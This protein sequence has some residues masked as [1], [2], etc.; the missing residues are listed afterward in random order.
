[1]RPRPE[2][3]A[4]PRSVTR[5][6][7]LSSAGRFA[8]LLSRRRYAVSALDQVALSLF[9]FVLNIALLAMLTPVQFGVV[10]LWIAVSQ[11]TI[12][13]QNAVIG[14]ALNTY[15]PAERDAAARRRLE[16]A[17]D[18]INLLMAIAAA[19]AI[20]AVDA[21]AE[22]D[23][24][25]R[26]TA[27][28]VAIPLFVVANLY[29]EYYR[30]VAFVRHDMVMLGLTDGPYLAVTCAC[31]AAMLAWPQRI[32]GLFAVF[33]TLS[34]GCLAAQLCLRRYLS[35][36]PV[37]LFP[38][39]WLATYR[40]LASETGWSLVGAVAV[41]AQ[42]RSY[43]YVTTGL[44]GLS[45]FAAINAVGV[46]FRPIG[47]LVTAWSRTALPHL[48]ACWS[49][50]QYATYYRSLRRAIAATAAGSIVW[51][52]LLWLVWPLVDRYVLAG[53]YPDSVRLLAPWA[54]ASTLSMLRMTLGIALQAAHEFKYLANV[55]LLCGGVSIAAVGA[56]VLVHDFTWA[57]YG[58]AIGEGLGLAM[59]AKRLAILRQAEPAS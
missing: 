29:R 4:P 34:A 59:H 12:G 42:A 14:T 27:V 31:L 46:M 41:Q 52:V 55:T 26:D 33:L 51:F 28:A 48:S 23:W 24:A 57:M 50:G 17:L 8:A 3:V 47:L 44:A 19:V 49:G 30:S 56:A 13:V 18:T 2:T 6:Y 35:E 5:P 10:S 20:V 7:S 43:V 11:L 39:G 40:A 36:R 1:M 38:A 53:K 22:A 37:R 16:A 21:F 32:G 9:S 58:I 15:V 25:P 45:A 54:V